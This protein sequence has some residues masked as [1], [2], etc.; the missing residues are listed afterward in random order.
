MWLVWLE[1]TFIQTYENLMFVRPRFF[2]SFCL[3]FFVLCFFLYR[4]WCC[5]AALCLC[6]SKSDNHLL[7]LIFK[8]LK[9]HII[10]SL[11]FES[12]VHW[13]FSNCM[14]AFSV[15]FL[16]CTEALTIQVFFWYIRN[17]IRV[18]LF[19]FKKRMFFLGMI[20]PFWYF[21]L[22]NITRR[23]FASEFHYS[24]CLAFH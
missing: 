7:F 11:K 9:G 4:K 13:L 8:E 22:G 14:L 23:S 1:W 17:Q 15:E 20:H 6:L 2:E 18:A 5:K 19:Y 10:V 16:L 12:C 21:K 24:V 3:S